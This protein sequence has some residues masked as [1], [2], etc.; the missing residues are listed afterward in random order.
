P[1]LT[2]DFALPALLVDA[3]RFGARPCVA[4]KGQAAGAIVDVAGEVRP[5]LHGQPLAR[6]TDGLAELLRAQEAAAAQ[7]WARRSCRGCAALSMFRR[8]TR[9]W[10]HAA[11]AGAGGRAHPA[12][13]RC[14]LAVIVHRIDPR[15]GVARTC[16]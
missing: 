1:E 10:R 5:C 4:D 14:A 6:A 13:A 2:I 11:P 3:C 7:A 9:R 12:P 8:R 16:R 15:A